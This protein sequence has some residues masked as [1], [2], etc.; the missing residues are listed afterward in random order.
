MERKG[1][2]KV[3]SLLSG[4]QFRGRIRRAGCSVMVHSSPRVL[5]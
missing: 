3:H 5:I 1:P 2:V 4:P